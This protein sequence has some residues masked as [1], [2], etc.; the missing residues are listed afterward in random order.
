[1]RRQAGLTKSRKPGRDDGTPMSLRFLEPDVTETRIAVETS[2]RRSVGRL[3]KYNLHG[4]SAVPVLRP[5]CSF[6]QGV[7]VL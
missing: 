6:H 7:Q 2:R 3:L 1:M 4:N 5:R